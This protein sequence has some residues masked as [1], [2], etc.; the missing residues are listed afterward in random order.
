MLTLIV[1]CVHCG[2]KREITS[3]DPNANEQPICDKDFMPMIPVKA[4][5]K[6]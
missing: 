5:L 4:K 2:E 3:N 1:K 6:R